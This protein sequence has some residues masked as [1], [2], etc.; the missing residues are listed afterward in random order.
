M[1]IVGTEHRWLQNQGLVR[2][3]QALSKSLVNK[4][5]FGLVY[6]HGSLVI[7]TRNKKLGL[8]LTDGQ[9]PINVC[10]TDGALGENRDGH[11]V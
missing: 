9:D 5:L 6:E 4:S 2:S 1:F 11:S 8:D 7:T 3:V 10:K